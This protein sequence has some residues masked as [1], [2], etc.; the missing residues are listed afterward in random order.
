M[1]TFWWWICWPTGWTKWT[2]SGGSAGNRSEE[3]ILLQWCQIQGLFSRIGFK[4]IHPPFF[5]LSWLWCRNLPKEVTQQPK[6]PVLSGSCSI[7]IENWNNG[8]GISRTLNPIKV[9]NTPSLLKDQKDSIDGN[10][11]TNAVKAISWEVDLTITREWI[12]HPKSPSNMLICWAGCISSQTVWIRLDSSWKKNIMENYRTFLAEEK[13]TKKRVRHT[14][15]WSMSTC[16]I[17]K[18]GCSKISLFR[19]EISLSKSLWML[20]GTSTYSLFL[21]ACSEKEFTQM[22]R[23][24]WKG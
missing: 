24:E 4:W 13:S 22:I 16:S 3:G 10:A 1:I 15:N 18:M 5:C 17:K 6:K 7:T 8:I 21:L 12:I 14:L 11:R 19:G 20:L 2:S 23:K 9:L